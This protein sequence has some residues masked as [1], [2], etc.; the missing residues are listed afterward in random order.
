MSAEIPALKDPKKIAIAA[1]VFIIIVALVLVVIF[2]KSLVTSA[3]SWTWHYRHGN[4]ITV[5]SCKITVPD[6]WWVLESEDG[7]VI[8]TLFSGE[9]TAFLGLT[10]MKAEEIETFS[11]VESLSQKAIVIDGLNAVLKNPLQKVQIGDNTAY[12]FSRRVPETDLHLVFWIFPDKKLV[13][14]AYDAP[15]GFESICQGILQSVS[16]IE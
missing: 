4:Y 1:V 16:A 15:P 12:R 14:S 9:K 10:V 11:D 8:K 7:S 2:R 3:F 13:F 6:G 5:G